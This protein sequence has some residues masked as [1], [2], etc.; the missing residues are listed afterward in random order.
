MEG[1]LGLGYQAGFALLLEPVAVALEQA[2]EDVGGQNLIAE[3][4]APPGDELIGGD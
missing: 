3:Y 1:L 4:G 2:V